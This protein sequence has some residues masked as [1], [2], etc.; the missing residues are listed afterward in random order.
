MLFLYCGWY[1]FCVI[2]FGCH[3]EH[4]PN[5][6]T[7]ISNSQAWDRGNGFPYFGPIPHIDILFKI[8]TPNLI[9][10]NNSHEHGF[11]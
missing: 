10:L 8:K 6:L 5:S 4:N 3:L 2:K 9:L 7:S 1:K 11:R